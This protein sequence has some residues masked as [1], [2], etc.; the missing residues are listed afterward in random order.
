MSKLEI[1][2]NKNIEV[3]KFYFLHDGSKTGHPCLVISKDDAKNRY[4]VVRF[5]SDKFG[6][7]PKKDRGVRHII[8]L[9]YPISKDVINSYVRNRPMLCKRR[10]IGIKELTNIRI[11]IDDLIIIQRITK[12]DPQL[13]PSLRK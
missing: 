9:K 7:T 5:D 6:D 3:G 1:K 13:S 12:K 2:Q 8:K 11:H 10:D 4:L